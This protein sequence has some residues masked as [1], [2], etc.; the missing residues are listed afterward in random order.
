MVWILVWICSEFGLN[1]V[2]ILA[3]IWSEF[4]SEFGLNFGLN[5]LAR[6]LQ[7]PYIHRVLRGLN[8][9]NLVWILVWIWSEFQIQRRTNVQ[10]LTCN[11][12]LSSSFFLSFLLFSSLW[13]KAL[14]F[15]GEVLGEK[16]WK[17]VKKCEKVRKSVKYY[18]TILPFSCCPLVFLWFWSE[19]WFEFGLNFGLNLVRFFVWIW[20]GFLWNWGCI[21][22]RPILVS[23]LYLF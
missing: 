17:S 21:L 16:F 2:W 8:V 18:E 22:S 11:V 1:L 12:D 19:Y 15:E 20:S 10:Q 6:F 13:A 23:L 9:L 4:W 7:K 14:C 5:C 3:W